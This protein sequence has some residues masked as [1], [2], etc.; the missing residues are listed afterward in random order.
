M[1]RQ[2]S[3]IPQVS[4][5]VD[6]SH[7]K[8]V[9]IEALLRILWFDIDEALIVRGPRSFCY[10]QPMIIRAWIHVIAGFEAAMMHPSEASWHVLSLF[11]ASWSKI[12]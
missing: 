6:V 11:R 5:D 9:Q 7:V 1:E 10:L 12:Y 8:V 4:A 3:Y 2:F